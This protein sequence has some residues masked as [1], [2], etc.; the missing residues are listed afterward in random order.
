VRLS[1][2]ALHHAVPP[3]SQT[4]RQ[5]APSSLKRRS[6]ASI[7]GMRLTLVGV[8]PRVFDRVA[9]DDGGVRAAPIPRPSIKS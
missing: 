8:R 1:P 2:A 7:V 3:A 4:R 5:C 9:V 6:R